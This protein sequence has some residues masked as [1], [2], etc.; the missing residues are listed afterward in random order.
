MSA[1]EPASGR[2]DQN[3][4]LEPADLREAVAG[5]LGIHAGDLDDHQDLLAL[6]L[7]S[8]AVMR[9][10]NLFRRAGAR[11]TFERLA[12]EPTLASWLA[13]LAGADL[14]P[15][16]SGPQAGRTPVD[17]NDEHALAPMQQAYWIGGQDGQPLGGVSAH[18]YAEFD[19]SDVDPDRLEAAV[20]ALLARHGMLRARFTPNGRQQVL[21]RSPWPGLTVHDLRGAAGEDGL[22]RL[23]TELSH[24]RFDIEGADVFDVQLSLLDEG[25]T[26]MHV[27]IAM[28]VA[29]AQSYQV[30]LADLA[31]L[32]REPG[33]GLRPLSYS[34][35][36]Y[37]ADQQEF[38]NS[39][40]TRAA[41]DYW[42]GRLANLPG[43]PQLPLAEGAGLREHRGVT[44]YYQRLS[45]TE[46]A[47]IAACAQAEALTL[48]VVFCTVYAEVLSRWSA[49]PRFLL[50]I[51]TFGRREL[52]DDVPLIVGDFTN[53]TLLSVDAGEPATFAE[54][55]RA[56]QAQLRSD[57]TH[58]DHSGVE[59][60]R[61]LAR[62]SRSNWPRA[63][64]VFTSV[65]G[66][67]ELFGPEVRECFGTPVWTSSETPQVWLD[68]QV[69]E[70]GDGGL[71]V[72]WDVT[73]GVFPGGLVEALTGAYEEALTSLTDA[74]SWQKPLAVRLPQSQTAV[75]TRANGTGG[76]LSLG[77]LH[78]RFF[79][80]AALHPDRTALAWGD[81]DE[82]SYGELADRA[83]RI[84][85]GLHSVG[86][87]P[88]DTVAVTAAK[89]PWQIAAVL[90]VLAAGAAYVP[91]GIDQPSARRERMYQTAGVGGVVCVG[92]EI[93]RLDWPGT[94]PVF[95]VRQLAEYQP[96]AWDG[97]RHDD[98]QLA[99]IIFTS[100]STG[101]PKGVEITHRAAMNTVM[102]VND[103][104]G[105][106]EHDRVL[107]LSALDFD[108]SVYDVFG[109]L[110]A[111]GA[112]VLVDELDRKE[113][114]SWG[115]LVRR[116]RVTVWNSVP[117]LL[118]MFLVGG[119]LSG[120]DDVPA[121]ILVSGDWVSADLPAQ[122][123]GLRPDA[124]F[125]ALGGA[126]EAAIWSNLLE[127]KDLRPEWTAVPYGYPLRAQRFRV[128]DGQGRDR[129]DWVPG[130][131]WIGGSGLAMGYR[132]QPEL[133]ASAFVHDGGERW[134][135]TGDL[136]RY[137]PDGMVEFLGR[138]DDQV[139]IGGHRIELGE[140]EAALARLPRVERAVAFPIGSPHRRIAAALVGADADAAKRALA[141]ALP[142]YMVPDEIV[143]LPEIPLTGTGKVDRR[144]LA[145]MV[146]RAHPTAS[147][148]EP[149][150]GSTEQ[151]LAAI[152]AEILD[153]PEVGRRDSFFGL[154][155]DSLQ[156]TRMQ[157]SLRT[158]LGV[159]VTLR[160][161]FSA[162]TV[163]ELAAVVD[164]QR[165]VAGEFEEGGI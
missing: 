70:G 6:G 40:A 17:E 71:L 87:S 147:R 120:P 42:R 118:E 128:T 131:L 94:L 36:Q 159:S 136:A 59:V 97:V 102:A 20:R 99:Y 126:T 83:R 105:I 88:G 26:R 157:E 48:P 3:R 106:D 52:H 58:A 76:A 133:T 129:P 72:N 60:L 16:G 122:V 22:A 92:D 119:G 116:H 32:Y 121:V 138:S 80:R 11:V 101:E 110:S 155:G 34:F 145:G 90:G 95:D 125:A 163:A 115:R 85:G 108:L 158:R 74:A 65:I 142:P 156:A 18:F 55:A 14:R 50:N 63:P 150:E 64:V 39:D 79:D 23:R 1:T 93:V 49:E 73:D 8:I 143:T 21:A 149:P 86:I 29:D 61:D 33:A 69:I 2:A 38:E 25:R 100:G 107:A 44:R 19:G 139:K 152:W 84:A 24:R 41:E 160:Q 134:Y 164:V 153:L 30:L 132:D 35:A 124:R 62:G 141:D 81:S 9:I 57:L 54:R 46:V 43:P 75:R 91:V 148:R 109:L 28:L 111:G 37:L 89:G 4:V 114:R 123:S 77:R 165:D 127:V 15:A 68:Q 31:T 5:L 113:A 27:G 161:L 137:L 151:A 144:R 66:M 104:F 78:E 112:I 45:A 47:R 82:L 51:P 12:E 146:E 154:G 56:V 135:R 162:P 140:I 98:D 103:H 53:V 130:E 117:A 67:G 13:L 7:E 96:M 10:A